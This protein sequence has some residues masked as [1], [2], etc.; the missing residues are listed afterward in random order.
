MNVFNLHSLELES[1]ENKP[2][3]A[4]SIAAD[5]NA[6]ELIVSFSAKLVDFLRNK[7]KEHN[8]NFP[9]KKITLN[10]LKE[11]YKRGANA[12]GE[13]EGKTHGEC[14]IAR[15]NMFLRILSSQDIPNHKKSTFAHS[16][17]IDITESWSPIS[18]DFTK[19]SE[20][21]QANGL[22]YNFSDVNNLYLDEE[23]A[24]TGFFFEV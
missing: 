18:E 16:H 23:S 3:S 22:D 1:G 21:I 14:A 12:F 8:K 9:K 15:V 2:Q 17:E 11:V 20:E 4:E 13:E 7:A 10:K 5:I 24:K 6:N 19:A